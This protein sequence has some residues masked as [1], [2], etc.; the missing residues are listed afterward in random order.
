MTWRWARPD[1]PRQ[2]P[3]PSLF[4]PPSCMPHLQSSATAIV[5]GVHT[6]QQ[7]ANSESMVLGPNG[8]QRCLLTTSHLIMGLSIRLKRGD[9]G[10]QGLCSWDADPG[11][12]RQQRLL[13]ASTIIA[14]G[15]QLLCNKL[16]HTQDF[17]NHHLRHAITDHKM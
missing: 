10:P 12:M 6:L 16:G 11:K 8:R 5:H 15:L 4:R 17:T 14:P 1:V 2:G 7:Y 13:I 9:L 3:V